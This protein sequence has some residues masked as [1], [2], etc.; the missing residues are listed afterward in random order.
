MNSQPWSN[1]VK[2][3]ESLPVASN[4]P[5]YFIHNV[6]NWEMY[7]FEFEFED[8]RKKPDIVPLLLPMFTTLRITGGVNG[9]KD[10]KHPDPSIALAKM[11]NNGFTVLNPRDYDYL[12]MYPARGGSYHTDKWTSVQVIGNEPIFEFDH[13]GFAEFRRALILEGKIKLPHKH[14]IQLMK[15]RKQRSI[16]RIAQDQHIPERAIQLR[17]RQKQIQDLIA[18]ESRLQKLGLSAYEMQE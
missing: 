3:R 1:Q 12:R 8:K 13:K 7:E 6:K 16:D 18:F 9:V 11:Q 10:G 2:N 17:K 15:I 4:S 5:Y 14:F